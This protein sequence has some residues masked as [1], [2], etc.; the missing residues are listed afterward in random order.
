MLLVIG[1]SL[2]TILSIIL[3]E[4]IGRKSDYDEYCAVE[5]R[6]PIVEKYKFCC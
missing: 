4:S 3:V 1:L 2:F 6:E 5:C